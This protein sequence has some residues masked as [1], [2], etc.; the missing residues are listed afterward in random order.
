[1]A[2]PKATTIKEAIKRWEDKTGQNPAT[3][4]EVSLVFQWP[5]IEKMDTS[6][7]ALTNCEYVN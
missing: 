4:T 3:A 1:M 6:L 2:A 5:P 7:S